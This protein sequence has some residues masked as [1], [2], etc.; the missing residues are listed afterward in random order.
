M[1]L[2]ELQLRR[3]EINLS[4]SQ[5][6]DFI[7][8]RRSIIICDE[9]MGVSYGNCYPMDHALIKIAKLFTSISCKLRRS[10]LLI[11]Q[12]KESNVTWKFIVRD[13]LFSF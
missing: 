5:S 4:S 7:I 13:E 6:S 2:N 3:G 9:F 8:A 10:G 11:A 1:L 12:M